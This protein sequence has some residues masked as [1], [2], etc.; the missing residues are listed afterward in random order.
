MTINPKLL[1]PTLLWENPNP[2][3][4]MGETTLTGLPDMS[5]FEYLGIEL[6]IY[7]P[8]NQQS[9]FQK[10][11]YQTDNTAPYFLGHAFVY[12]DT[13]ASNIAAGGV[14]GREMHILSSTSIKFSNGITWGYDAAPRY[15]ANHSVVKRIYGYKY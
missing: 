2:N 6:G 4:T 11:R 12:I 14:V 15:S 8:S 9:Y 5:S 10:V 3:S 13:S 7:T 1:E